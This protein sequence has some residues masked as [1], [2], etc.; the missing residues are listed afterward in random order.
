MCYCMWGSEEK[1]IFFS[2][3][4][5]YIAVTMHCFLDKGQ[6][7]IYIVKKS[8]N[9]RRMIFLSIKIENFM[10][11]ITTSSYLSFAMY[12]LCDSG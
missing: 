7:D 6:F 3:T 8:P 9:M 1:S 11:W 5:A 10:E 2:C 4:T 12:K